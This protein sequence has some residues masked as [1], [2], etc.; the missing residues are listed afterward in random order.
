MFESGAI[1]LYLADHYDT[2]GKVSYKSDTAEYYDMFSW[3]MIQIAGIGL[4][5]GTPLAVQRESRASGTKPVAG[6]GK[7]VPSR[8]PCIFKL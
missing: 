1:M 3:V 6:T 4:M 7:L 2:D 5:Q 8:G